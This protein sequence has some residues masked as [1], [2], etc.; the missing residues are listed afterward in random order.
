MSK[1]SIGVLK[2]YAVSAGLS[3]KQSEA[4]CRKLAKSHYENFLVATFLLP[5]HLK[6]HFYNIYAYCRVSD[7]LG[8]EAGDPRISIQLLEDW[9]LE[10]ESCFRGAPRHP[11]FIALSKTIEEFGIPIDPFADLLKAFQQDQI[12]NRYDTYEQLLEYCRFSA[13]PV[14]HLVLYLCGYRDSERQKLSD[15]TC[16]ALQLANHW[17]DIGRDLEKLNR[18]YLPKEDMDQ[19]GYGESDLKK[20][21]CDDRFA[22]LLRMEVDRARDFF[23]RGQSLR[24]R[25]PSPFSLE[26]DLFARCGLEVLNRIEKAG[27]DVFSK[28][29]TLSKFERF[30]ILMQGWWK[31]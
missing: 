25:L 13:N 7:D 9:K 18:I 15:Y 16:T 28:R 17:Q 14:G 5:R 12:Q 10:L 2:N 19:F 11:V 29:P 8:D 31:K 22:A 24:E 23:H 4:F 27:Y 3:L 1:T 21:I 20:H 6:Q 30:K 26:I